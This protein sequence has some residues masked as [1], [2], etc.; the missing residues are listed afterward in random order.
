MSHRFQQRALGGRPREVEICVVL[1]A[2]FYVKSQG[3]TAAQ[4]TCRL[5]QMANSLHVFSEL[6]LMSERG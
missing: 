5:S 4:P 3:C 2:I 1:N 6:A